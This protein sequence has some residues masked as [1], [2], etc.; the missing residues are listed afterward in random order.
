MAGNKYL[1]LNGGVTTEV[2]ASQTSGANVIVALDA[3]GKLNQNMMPA[4]MGPEMES[5]MAS[6]VIAGGDFVN[7]FNDSGTT[8]VRKADANSSVKE[9]DGFSLTGAGSGNM[10]D[11]YA[12]GGA[13][14]NQM[15][16][17]TKGARQ[18]LSDANPGKTIE[19]APVGTGKI[20]QSLGRA[21]SATELVPYY[22][23]PIV[24]A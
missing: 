18:F 15:S 12:L 4:G 2:A 20:L 10:C 14:N 13:L 21:T 3:T 16:G 23:E 6:E 19:I 5:I 24:L 1:S 11:V 8:K 9:A 22:T 7:K 17:M